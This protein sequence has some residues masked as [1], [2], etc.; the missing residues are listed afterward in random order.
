M[1]L[2]H[3]L[4]LVSMLSFGGFMV[5]KLV[6]A[7]VTPTIDI[8]PMWKKLEADRRKEAALAASRPPS[9]VQRPRSALS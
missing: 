4:L 7:M 9:G 6:H 1:R 2:S 3:T 8:I 5:S